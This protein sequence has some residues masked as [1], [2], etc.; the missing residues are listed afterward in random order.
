MLQL[1]IQNILD[2]LGWIILIKKKK[3]KYRYF[4]ETCDTLKKTILC[5][6]NY[7]FFFFFKQI[8]DECWVV[9]HTFEFQFNA[10]WNFKRGRITYRYFEALLQGTRLNG[11]EV[12]NWVSQYGSTGL[13]QIK[14]GLFPPLYCCNEPLLSF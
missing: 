10:W 12:E 1:T 2:I 4:N 13:D 3:C 11:I 9:T 5:A 14:R 8:I 6:I 7:F